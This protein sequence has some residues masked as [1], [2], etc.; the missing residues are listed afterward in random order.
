MHGMRSVLGAE[1]FS[2]V[3]P[4]GI[5]VWAILMLTLNGL[6]GIMAMPHVMASVGTGKNE[7]SCRAVSSTAIF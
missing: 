5:G 2:I 6:I 3:T 4:E 1:K 7:L